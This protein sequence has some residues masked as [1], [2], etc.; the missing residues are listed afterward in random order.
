MLGHSPE[1]AQFVPLHVGPLLP[2]LF[3]PSC[4][5]G[6]QSTADCGSTLGLAVAPGERFPAGT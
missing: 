4:L 2:P 5:E 6:S 3:K 1:Q